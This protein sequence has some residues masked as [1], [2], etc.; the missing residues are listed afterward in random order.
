VE[1]GYIGRVHGW[2]VRGDS[3]S[4][5]AHIPSRLH[6]RPQSINM[7]TVFS[8]SLARRSSSAVDAFSSRRLHHP[9]PWGIGSHAAH[10][11]SANAPSTR[12]AGIRG[13]PAG[14][15]FWFQFREKRVILRERI[16]TSHKVTSA[17]GVRVLGY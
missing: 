4:Q 11:P 3:A 8:Q 2:F 1:M 12:S 13:T 10:L 16:I 9:L 5:S 14:G 7:S 6:K 15:R 17:K